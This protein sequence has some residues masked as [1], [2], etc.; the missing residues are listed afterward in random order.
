MKFPLNIQELF[1]LTFCTHKSIVIY[2]ERSTSASPGDSL[3]RSTKASVPGTLT[4]ILLNQ[5]W[6][7]ATITYLILR[8]RDTVIET[9]K[10][11]TVL[12]LR[13]KKGAFYHFQR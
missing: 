7:H 11:E 13:L 3:V 10:Y 6:A 9:L 8:Q 4:N 1:E 5:S 2:L 12:P